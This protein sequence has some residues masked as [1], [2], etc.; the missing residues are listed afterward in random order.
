VN[1][2]LIVIINLRSGSNQLGP[3]HET[4]PL[5]SHMLANPVLPSYCRATG[6]SLALPVKSP[7]LNGVFMPWLLS[8]S[9]AL[10]E[11]FFALSVQMMDSHQYSAIDSAKGEIRLLKLAPNRECTNQTAAVKASLVIASLDE[12][13]VSYEALSYACGAIQ[14]I[15]DP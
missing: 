7:Q 14:M 10:T 6:R 1:K 4:A 5:G 3:F 15:L 9:T 2:I 11:F 12:A 13:V 8:R